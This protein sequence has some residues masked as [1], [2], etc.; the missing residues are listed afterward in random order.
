[1]RYGTAL[2]SV[3]FGVST[4]RAYHLY[5]AFLYALGSVAIYALVRAVGGTRAW[6]WIA[7]AALAT[8]SPSFLVLRS[9]RE[10]SL[11]RMPQRLNV[12][13]KW[14]EGPHIS[15]LALLPLALACA[16]LAIREGRRV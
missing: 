5:T 15:A 1:M 8:L 4:A 6:A 13:I 16:W 14:G 7:A 12:L 2:A 11:L 3:L 9:F 10:D